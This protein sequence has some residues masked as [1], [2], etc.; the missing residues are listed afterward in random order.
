MRV[1][2]ARMERT[3]DDHMP[4]DEYKLPPCLLF[5]D[6]EKA[7]DSVEHN[8]VLRAM[9]DQVRILQETM[10]ESHTEITLFERPLKISMQRGV[11]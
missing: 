6:F 5:V 7:F 8:A 3:M 1:I 4:R 9:N 2:Y 10:R 11:K